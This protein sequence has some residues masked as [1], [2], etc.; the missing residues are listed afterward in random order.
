MNGSLPPV[1][2]REFL[3]ASAAALVASRIPASAQI[4]A[5]PHDADA[6]AIPDTG[7]RLW[8]DQNAEWKND[9]IYLPDDVN[10]PSLPVNPP[11]GG[12]QAL[13]ATQGIPVTLP[14]TVEQYFWGLQG[15]RPYK[16]EYRFETSDDEVKN[17]AYYGV[18]WWWRTIDSPAAFH[19]KRI[20]L[21]IRA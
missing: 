17:G 8:P 14:C 7:W 20:F 6:L 18:S 15:M 13:S 3:Q 12:W 9:T 16:D 1:N 11:T 19:G 5:A 2:R 4:P 10:L 21:H